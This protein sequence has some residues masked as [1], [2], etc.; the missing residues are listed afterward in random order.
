MDL[1]QD[2]IVLIGDCP[3]EDAEALLNLI[4][5]SSDMPVDLTRAG[6]LHAAVFQALLT[7]QVKQIG[8]A[9][10][11]FVERWLRPPLTGTANV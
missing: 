8:P 5:S 9:A 4:A 7:G 11:Q 10:D 2:R 1:Q 6:H 3:I